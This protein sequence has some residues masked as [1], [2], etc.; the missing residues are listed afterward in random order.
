MLLIQ[1]IV[2]SPKKDFLFRLTDRA[3]L[4]RGAVFS[5][6]RENLRSPGTRI[7]S[8]F[9]CISVMCKGLSAGAE[10]KVYNILFNQREPCMQKGTIIS[11]YPTL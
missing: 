3:A 4:P 9:I 5:A 1:G 6:F 7:G 2:I 10:R 8:G 11:Q